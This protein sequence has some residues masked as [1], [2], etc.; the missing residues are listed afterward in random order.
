VRPTADV[1]A[2][3]AEW[4]MASDE[5]KLCDVIVGGLD[6]VRAKDELDGFCRRFLIPY[7]DQGMDVHGDAGRHLISGQVILSSPGDPCLR[8]YG[9]VTD[10]ALNRE[11]QNY[12]AAA[13]KPQVVW[14]NGVLASTAVGLVMQMVTP[15]FETPIESAYLEYDGNTGTIGP[16]YRVKHLAGRACPHY[17]A[18][19]RGD[20]LFDIR[21]ATD[22]PPTISPSANSAP[23]PVGLWDR[24]KAFFFGH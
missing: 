10:E 3:K 21:K 17:P 14:P 11:G 12:G 19:E 5:L 22:A 1:K 6:S 15:W 24:I 18:H 7:I 23:G 16:S 20:P 8:C 13:G 9:L 2:I 4:Q